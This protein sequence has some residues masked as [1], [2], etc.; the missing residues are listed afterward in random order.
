L[1][2]LATGCSSAAERGRGDY[3]YCARHRRRCHYG[4]CRREALRLYGRCRMHAGVVAPF[5]HTGSKALVLG[6]D[7]HWAPRSRSQVAP[8]TTRTGFKQPKA[9]CAEVDCGRTVQSRCGGY[10]ARHGCEH[11][12]WRSPRT[13]PTAASDVRAATLRD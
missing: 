4:R 11:D 1:R 13:A 7:Q 2:C 8:A 9:R 5:W 6:V 12:Y 10:S 3:R